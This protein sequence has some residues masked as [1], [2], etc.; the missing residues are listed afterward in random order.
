MLRFFPAS[1]APRHILLS[2]IS[3]LVVVVFI[4]EGQETLIS[5]MNDEALLAHTFRRSAAVA[6]PIMAELFQKVSYCCFKPAVFI[7]RNI[8]MLN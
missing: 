7:A 6:L 5:S 1:C 8:V 3:A 4:D 2:L